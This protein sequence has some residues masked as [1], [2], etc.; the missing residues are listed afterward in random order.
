[1]EKNIKILIGVIAVVI[2][3]LVL[4]VAS[5]FIFNNDTDTTNNSTINITNNNTTNL[6]V[7]N[8]VENKATEESV[9]KTVYSAYCMICGAGLS[10]AEANDW[11]NQGKVCMD[12]AN[13]P[14]YHTEEGS[15]YANEKLGYDSSDNLESSSQGIEYQAAPMDQGRGSVA[16]R[17]V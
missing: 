17:P 5:G 16:S 6:T 14:Y 10:T 2:V 9:E 4:V 3:L 11:Y 1:M 7:N 15:K 8:T 12:C 13:N